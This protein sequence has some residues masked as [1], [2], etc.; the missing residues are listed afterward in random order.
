MWKRLKITFLF[1]IFNRGTNEQIKAFTVR[2]KRE[3]LAVLDC[4]HFMGHLDVHG[5]SNSGKIQL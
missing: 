3:T 1:F 4:S 2:F 5:D